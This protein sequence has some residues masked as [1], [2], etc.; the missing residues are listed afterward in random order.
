ME[1][2][3]QMSDTFL[4]GSILAM[5]GGF[6]DAYTYLARGHV[7]ANAQTGNIVLLGM[8]LAEG[9]FIEASYYL[10]PIMA[11]VLGIIITEAVKKKYKE[12]TNV[13]WRQIVVAVE[14]MV[15]MSVALIP[16]GKWNMIANVLVSLVCSMQVQSFRKINGNVATT[17]M[18]TGNLRSGTEHMI[19][20]S[21]TKERT[22][23]N[24]GM[25]YYGIII[26]FIL[27]AALGVWFTNG[28]AT[29]AVL[30]CCILLSIALG[31]MFIKKK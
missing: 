17:T 12:R 3:S 16:A 21:Q 13:H 10:I 19:R 4:L 23:L 11:F 26:F 15:L 24:R 6:L 27:G 30:V 22:L 29:Y 25:Q 8:N 14:I 5:A 9:N 20:Y 1:S 28:L 7:F 31:I 2:K 18:C